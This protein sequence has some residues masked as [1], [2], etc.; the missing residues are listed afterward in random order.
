MTEAK[1]FAAFSKEVLP[2][3]FLDAIEVAESQSLQFDEA[4]A[5]DAQDF[6]REAALEVAN[7]Y[8]ELYEDA[9]LVLAEELDG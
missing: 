5:A 2:A 4:L 1:R 6:C 8:D 7:R 9:L 3:A